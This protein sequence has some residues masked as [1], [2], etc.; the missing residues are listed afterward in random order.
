MDL[1]S[2]RHEHTAIAQERIRHRGGC[3]A[4][5]ATQGP[6]PWF[7]IQGYRIREGKIS[8][9][10]DLRFD[11][12]FAAREVPFLLLLFERLPRFFVLNA[13]Y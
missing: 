3:H 2:R 4:S 1:N 13:E 8:M 6:R 9:T 10:D 5:P 7:T 11:G 12:V